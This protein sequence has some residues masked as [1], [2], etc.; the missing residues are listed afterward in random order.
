MVI[1]SN[2]LRTFANS[3]AVEPCLNR[4]SVLMQ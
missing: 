2:F 1:Y 3:R 4:M